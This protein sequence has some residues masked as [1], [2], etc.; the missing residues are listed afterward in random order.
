MHL[1]CKAGVCIR[2]CPCGVRAA[3]VA[4]WRRPDNVIGQRWRNSRGL[5]DKVGYACTAR[6]ALALFCAALLH[7]LRTLPACSVV[8]K[9]RRKV[10]NAFSKLF[11]APWEA[12][13]TAGL[14]SHDMGAA[15]QSITKSHQIIRSPSVNA[16]SAAVRSK[17]RFVV[18]IPKDLQTESTPEIKA[19]PAFS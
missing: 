9:L 1:S 3:K 16:S 15:A 11:V 2:R 18:G 4:L 7:S 6:L 12:S 13:V 17:G 19:S 10:S 14:P 5:L 8:S